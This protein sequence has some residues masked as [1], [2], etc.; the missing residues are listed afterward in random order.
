[1]V[2]CSVRINGYG[3]GRTASLAEEEGRR[4]ERGKVDANLQ[5]GREKKRGV[6]YKPGR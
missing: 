1:V 5:P 3:F 2:L 6:K 4:V